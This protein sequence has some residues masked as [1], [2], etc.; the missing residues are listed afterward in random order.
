MSR[1]RIASCLCFM[2][3]IALI[4]GMAGCQTNAPAPTAA[5][6]AAIQATATAQP[7]EQPTPAPTETPKGVTINVASSQNWTKDV[8]KLLADQFN[9]ETGNTI[10][11]VLTPDD[12][13]AN[14]LKAKFAT[15][16]GPDIFLSQGGTGVAQFQP[17]QHCLDL[18]GEPWVA[19]LTDWAKAGGTW[20]GKLMGF[21]TWS[22]DGWGFLYVPS[23]FE[24]AGVKIPKTYQEFLSVCEAIK[25]K[26]YTPIYEFGKAEWHQEVCL[27]TYSA[28]ANNTTP[29]LYDKLNQ[30]QAK[31]ADQ[32]VL[33][34]ALTQMKEL[35]DKGYY[36]ENFL[37]NTWEGTIDAM[38]S[39]KY[40]MTL[41]YSTFQNEVLAKF[42]D[43]KADTWQMFPSPLADN[44]VWATSAGGIYRYVN[45]DSKVLDACKAYLSFLC[46]TDNLKTYYDARKDL[47]PCSFKDYPGNVS[48]GY[49]TM[50]AN[51]SGTGL[52]FEGGVLY[53]DQSTIGKLVQEMYLGTKTPKQVL[54]AIDAYRDKMF[55]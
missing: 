24:A 13:Y 19:N 28:L 8:D 46:K 53:W 25:A 32:A 7:T 30:N 20:N 4:F 22:V 9:K 29:G 37:A 26:G 31:F 3:A 55:K 5:P 12:Q 11:F 51:S 10:N 15:G 14:V 17:D 54:E 34:T 23:I 6:T 16:E 38:G 52:D 44:T 41:V 27:N 18:S 45:K 47:G 35:N 39:G 2:M 49:K 48:E 40:A 43:S 36:G 1:I 42:P 50:M 33:E 21:S